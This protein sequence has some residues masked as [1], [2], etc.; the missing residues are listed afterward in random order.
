MILRKTLG[1]LQGFRGLG[2]RPERDWGD[3]GISEKRRD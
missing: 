3:G 2:E 1:G